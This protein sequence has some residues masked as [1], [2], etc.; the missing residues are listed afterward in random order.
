MSETFRIAIVHYHLRTGGVTRVIQHASSAL[1]GQVKMVVIVGEPP[2]VEAPLPHVAVING[3]GYEG[4]RQ[5]RGAQQLVQ[6]MRM[7]ARR[8]LGAP[9]H[10]WHFHNH[11]LGKSRVLPEVVYHLAQTG[12]RLLLQLHDFAEDGRPANYRFLLDHLGGDTGKLGALLY[13]QASHVHYAVLNRRDQCFLQRAG[14]PETHLHL[15]P[16]AVW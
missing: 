13:P 10:I 2:Q 8:V 11:A 3:L 1:S 12:E 9:P 6:Q 4:A 5:K 16:N 7:A 15:L 14:V